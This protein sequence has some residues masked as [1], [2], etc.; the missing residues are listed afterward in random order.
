[1]NDGIL[2][3]AP[4]AAAYGLRAGDEGE[5]TSLVV[6]G[7]LSSVRCLGACRCAMPAIAEATAIRCHA[8][9]GRRLEFET[10][11]GFAGSRA[12]LLRSCPGRVV[13]NDAMA[14]RAQPRHDVGLVS[15][16]VVLKRHAAA[17]S[18]AKCEKTGAW[19]PGFRNYHAGLRTLAAQF[20]VHG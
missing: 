19:G 15:V 7:H 18:L 20:V 9:G 6:R 4:G 14:A 10:Q 2:V 3:G 1:V 8:F 12:S 11:F 17:L 5:G 13:V 16:N